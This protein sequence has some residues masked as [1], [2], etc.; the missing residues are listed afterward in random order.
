M[1]AHEH[2]AQ[3]P[4]LDLLADQTRVA[5]SATACCR[6]SFLPAPATVALVPMQRIVG[7]PQRSPH[8]ADEPRRV[9][10]STSW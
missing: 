1:T 5:I 7:A 2:T 8:T 6:S 9:G 3:V 10:P 4:R